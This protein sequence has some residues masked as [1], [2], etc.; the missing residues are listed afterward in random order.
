[1]RY[2]LGHGPAAV[3]AVVPEVLSTPGSP[4]A[5][6]FRQRFDSL[7][8]HDFSHIRVHTGT[9]AADAAVAV[10][11]RA[12]TVGS[13]LVF[14]AGE[15]APGNRSGASLV[16]HELTHVLQQEKS[17][18][19][20]NQGLR[21][22]DPQGQLEQ[23]AKRAE[24]THSEDRLELIPSAR[25]RPGKLPR[26]Q[27]VTQGQLMRTPLP[28]AGSQPIAKPSAAP[29][30]PVCMAGSPAAVAGKSLLFKFDSVDLLAG[31]G[32]L[33]SSLVTEGMLSQ[34]IEVHGYASTEGSAGYNTDL[35]CRRALSIKDLLTSNLVNAPIKVVSH[36]ET[37][38]YGAASRNRTATLVMTPRKNEPVTL[39]PGYGW[40]HVETPAESAVLIRLD[41]LAKVAAP[42]GP[43]E[44]TTGADFS[45][46][47]ADFRAALKS[48]MDAVPYSEPLP[49]DVDIIMKALV[50]WSTDP[51][52]QWGEGRW[53]S[54]DLIMSAHEYAT[55]P[56]SQYKCN[57]YVAE[58]VYQ[59][60]ALVFKHIPAAESPG[61]YYPFQAHEWHDPTV[62][63]P[64]FTVVTA[65]VMGDVYATETHSGIYLGEYAGKR[66]YV[67][68]R[69]TGGGVFALDSV[70]KKHGV[71]IKVIPEPGVF[72]HYTP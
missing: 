38:A 6:N 56:A 45:K 8:A 63:I 70:Q 59:S 46:A 27:S 7:F 33:V 31:Q 39:P 72:R 30:A 54:N 3:P 55:V 21:L 11:A 69:D 10:N 49:P 37:T 66:L 35:S 2:G 41:R 51:G 9:R 58:V 50:I 22:D 43:E 60:L 12:F 71:Q 42:E 68:A 15:Y 16:A 64:H 29:G 24:T 32:A 62:T 17:I 28:T 40:P 34:D 53:D 14:G 57:A 26:S 61:H 19:G 20:Q 36:G 4:L 23:E 25:D 1:M 52:N 5:D 13:H 67:S 44:G 65:P 48:Q 47:V 18:G